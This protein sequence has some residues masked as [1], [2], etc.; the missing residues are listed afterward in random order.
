MGI[1]NHALCPIK[2]IGKYAF[3]HCFRNTHNIW[4]AVIYTTLFAIK[5]AAT[6][7]CSWYICGG[8]DVSWGSF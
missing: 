1:K 2:K 6:I 4:D 8:P 7:Y 5:T 3:S